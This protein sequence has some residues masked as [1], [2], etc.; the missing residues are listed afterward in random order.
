VYVG[1]FAASLMAM[2]FMADDDVGND[3][4]PEAIIIRQ[5]ENA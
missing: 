3:T 4:L 5:R 2:A 1:W